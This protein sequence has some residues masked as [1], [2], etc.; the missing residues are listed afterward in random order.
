MSQKWYTDEKFFDQEFR[1]A[2]FDGSLGYKEVARFENKY[3]WPKRTLFGF[4][5]WPIPIYDAVSPRV[6]I[7]ERLEK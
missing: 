2:I 3:L 4:A 1:R 6:V 5:G 7:F